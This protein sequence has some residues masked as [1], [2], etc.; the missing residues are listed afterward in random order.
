MY[1]LL[2]AASETDSSV[3]NVRAIIPVRNRNVV[4][5][6]RRRPH[7]AAKIVDIRQNPARIS[8]HLNSGWPP[9]G[10]TPLG[11]PGPTEEDDSTVVLIVIFAVTG[12][13]PFKVR[14]GGEKVQ[15]VS[16]F[17]AVA[18]VPCGKPEQ[19]RRTTWSNPFDGV[20]VTV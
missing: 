16:G 19:P 4:A 14:A 9:G 17:C 2:Q 12:V 11:L 7:K 8:H 15:V 20:T 18:S 3:A 1:V 10:G 13:V 6:G 5:P